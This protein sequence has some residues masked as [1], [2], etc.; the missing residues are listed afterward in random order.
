MKVLPVRVLHSTNGFL[1]ISSMLAFGLWISNKIL[2]CCAKR[3]S[4]GFQANTC[5]PSRFTEVAGGFPFALGSLAI[6]LPISQAMYLD[7]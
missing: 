6:G 5:L 1:Y 3:A 7:H 2:M 4:S